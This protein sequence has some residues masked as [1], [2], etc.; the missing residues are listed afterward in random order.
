[1]SDFKGKCVL[2]TGGALGLGKLMAQ[3]SLEEGAKAAILWDINQDNLN[4]TAEEFRA[5]GWTIHTAIVDVSDMAQI[6]AEAEKTLRDIGTVDILFNN[7]G[8]VIGKY[9]WEHTSRDIEMAIR[10]NVLGVMH[11]ARVFLPKMIEQKSG[12]IIN[13]ASA[14]GMMSLPKQSTYCGSKW[15]VLGWSEALRLELESFHPG[16]HVTTVCPSYINTGMF[17]GVKAPLFTPIMQPDDAVNRII[18]AVKRNRIML[19]MP[20][21]VKTLPFLRG[22]QPMRLFDAMAGRIFG[23]YGSM[24]NFKGR[25]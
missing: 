21:M 9:F 10:I 5:K 7:A 6:D 22:I 19:R 14:A 18:L 2:V 15:S 3:R 13:I 11:L 20:F 25:K 24:E 4:A 16:V 12:H 23:V 17:D 8:I 1:M